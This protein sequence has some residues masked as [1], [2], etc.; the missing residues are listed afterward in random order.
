[1]MSKV[2]Y[3]LT[4]EQKRDICEWISHIKFSD[5]YASNLAR[6]VNIKEFRMHS[7]K[8]HDCHVFMQNLI[9]IAFCEMLPKHVWSALTEVSLLIQILYSMTPDVNKVQELEGSVATIL[10]DFEKIFPSV[11]FDSME[12]LIVHLPYEPRVGRPMQYR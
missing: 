4:K 6:C 7:M 9:P 3:T 11:F 12:H 1:M 8:N 2:V 5:G 10:Y